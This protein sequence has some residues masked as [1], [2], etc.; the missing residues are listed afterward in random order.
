MS[1]RYTAVS[2]ATL[3]ISGDYH[4]YGF[5]ATYKMAWHFFLSIHAYTVCNSFYRAN[6]P[7]VSPPP[8]GI[9]ALLLIGEYDYKA[10]CSCLSLRT[11]SQPH[12]GT[13]ITLYG[14]LVV[15]SY[16]FPSHGR[17]MPS[18]K[19]M[20]FTPVTAVYL[21]AEVRR[22]ALPICGREGGSF[23]FLLRQARCCQPQLLRVWTRKKRM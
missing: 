12:T 4:A 20:T 21:V 17:E 1:T 6:R 8:P 2:G 5:Q 3:R 9:L 19:G 15:K 11:C 7:F 13:T 18:Q 10:T 22:H 23:P 16:V 14:R